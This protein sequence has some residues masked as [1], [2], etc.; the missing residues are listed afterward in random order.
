MSLLSHN[1]QAF[2]AIVQNGTVH[3]AAHDLGLTQTGVTQRIRSIER[4]LNTTLFLRSRKG[5]Q[6]TQEGDALLRYC[7]GTEELEGEA[8]SHIN[9]GGKKREILMSI[10]GPTSIMNSRVIP[11][12]LELYSIWPNLILN[13]IINDSVDRLA[14]VKGGQ[15][16]MAIL[17]PE[18][19]PNE[20]DS[21][22]LKPDRYIL[23]G[24]PSWKGRR[25]ADILE[26]ERVIDFEDK[27]PTT[28]NYLKKYKLVSHLKK[29]RIFVNSNESI[30]KMFSKGVGFGTLTQEIARP[31]IESGDLIQLNG[32]AVMDDP[33]ALCWYSR[34]QIPKYLEDVIKKIG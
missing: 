10:V 19:V 9:G 7:K 31:Y 11:R 26:N 5:M 30:I 6:L 20:M 3:G 29:T 23:V 33:Q 12:C 15:A 17:P 14:M 27:D 1:L 24:T 22:M 13:F 25:T 8:Y 4:E 32:G 34:P 28:L 18:S 21:K 16:T 2:I